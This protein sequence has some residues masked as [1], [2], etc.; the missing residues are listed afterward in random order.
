MFGLRVSG[1]FH[2][3]VVDGTACGCRGVCFSQARAISLELLQPVTA[4]KPVP[5]PYPR[6]DGLVVD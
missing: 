6:K 3:Q 1:L 2:A 5:Y 4:C